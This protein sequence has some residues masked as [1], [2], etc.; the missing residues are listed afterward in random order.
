MPK[1]NR[2]K[3]AKKGGDDGAEGQL[4]AKMKALLADDDDL[5]ANINIDDAPK[6]GK[7][8]QG[9]KDKKGKPAAAAPGSDQEEIDS[10][11]DEDKPKPTAKKKGQVSVLCL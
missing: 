1:K 6:K 11:S 10:G 5:A 7:K 3:S 2:G 4:T 9:K 8:I